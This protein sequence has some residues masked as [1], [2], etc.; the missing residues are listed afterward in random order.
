VRRESAFETTADGG[1][2]MDAEEAVAEVA[3]VIDEA[4]A[5]APREVVSHVVAVA[6]SCFWHSLV[7]VDVRD[8]RTLT[9]MLGWADTRAREMVKVLRKRFDERATHTRTGCRFHP[10]YWLPKLL[11]LQE[12]SSE[13][14]ADKNIRWMSFSDF[15]ALRFFGKTDTS[16]SMASGTGLLNQHTC[17]WDETLL[18]KFALAHEQL[19]RLTTDK[20]TFTLEG[21]YA[22][23]WSSL[24]RD[25]LWFPAIGDGATN[26]IGAG[27]AS[28]TKA[29]LMIGTSGAMRV[30]YEGRVPT[31]IPDALWCYR[32]DR[33]RVIVGGALSDG[34][35]L[36]SW[37]MNA[38]ALEGDA[39]EIESALA[40]SAP[41]AHGLTILPFWAGERST[42]WHAGA[43]GA[44]LG[45]TMHTRPLE[46][47]RACAEAI[48]YRFA[49]IADA[50]SQVAPEAFATDAEICASGGA[51]RAS[52]VWTQIL[53]DV[54]NRPIKLLHV[55]ESS[56][57]GAVL[58][59]LEALGAIKNIS[60]IP[61]QSGE[62]YEPRPEHHARYREAL[63]RQQKI[64]ELLVNNR[65]FDRS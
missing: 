55:R 17:A 44:I 27:C 14:Y 20:E 38:L 52:P 45:L 49:H 12:H 19:P 15:L 54:L 37:I 29:A 21:E 26:N 47:L 16:I 60:E 61:A 1:A 28:R 50:L 3:R 23:R 30:L 5:R 40:A 39:G 59:A 11:W 46:I 24:R 53:A 42:G 58:L 2:Q 18:S 10:T 51:L 31:E 35:G 36:Y 32:A 6:V 25:C 33:K 7:G 4:L 43:S 65:E 57:R 48:A 34:G 8:G 13:K 22:Q 64:Y 62:I 63:E 56:S 41:D 9:P